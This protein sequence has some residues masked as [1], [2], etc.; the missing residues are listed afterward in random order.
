MNSKELIMKPEENTMGLFRNRIGRPSAFI[1]KR[2]Q[3]YL[4]APFSGK[5]EGTRG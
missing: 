5:E 1:S 3:A 2:I 4:S